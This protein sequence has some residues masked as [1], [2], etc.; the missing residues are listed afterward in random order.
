MHCFFGAHVDPKEAPASVKQLVGVVFH[1]PNNGRRGAVATK[2]THGRSFPNN[3]YMGVIVIAG[4]FAY[5]LHVLKQNKSKPFIDSLINSL[6][7]EAVDKNLF[8]VD[9]E[10][11]SEGH[12]YSISNNMLDEFYYSL[13]FLAA[14]IVFQA[15]TRF[16]TKRTQSSLQEQANL[17]LE[18]NRNSKSNSSLP[19][20][21]ASCTE[22]LDGDEPPVFFEL[23]S[24]TG[25]EMMSTV[26]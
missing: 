7:A 15:I 10:T 5:Y 18:Q 20:L 4:R 8:F 23:L 13:A 2:K 1:R 6:S 25:S 16:S 24:Q 26:R 11:R 22:S 19:E 12:L 3:K 9:P 21:D 17:R 14:A